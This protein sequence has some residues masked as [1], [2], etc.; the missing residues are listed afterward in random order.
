MNQ[1]IKSDMKLA[2]QIKHSSLNYAN[3]ARTAVKKFSSLEFQKAGCKQVD[4]LARQARNQGIEVLDKECDF[5]IESKGKKNQALD[6]DRMKVKLRGYLTEQD[7]QELQKV[8]ARL[9]GPINIEKLRKDTLGVPGKRE[10][11]IAAQ[12]DSLQ[13]YSD[14]I[15]AIVR[16]NEQQKF[17]L[18]QPA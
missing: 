7:R 13:K 8:Q 10:D 6:K 12:M 3:A 4:F 14:H 9:Y 1:Q 16:R 2:Q 5:V 18:T 15:Q 11:H 17:S